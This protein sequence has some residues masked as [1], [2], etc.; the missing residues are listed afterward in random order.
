M[1]QKYPD[2]YQHWET[3]TRN[4][5]TKAKA[6]FINKLSL[7]I[8]KANIIK[9]YWRR[10]TYNPVYKLAQRKILEK[11]CVEAEDDD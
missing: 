5:M 3:I 7:Q 6:A 11:A 8:I 1:I 10:C 2:K 9:R 4:S